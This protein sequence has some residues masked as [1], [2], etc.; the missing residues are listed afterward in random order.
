[1]STLS[2]SKVFPALTTPPRSRERSLAIRYQLNLVVFR[3]QPYVFRMT[4][5]RMRLSTPVSF[6]ERIVS[7]RSVGRRTNLSRCVESTDPSILRGFLSLSG[8]SIHAE[9]LLTYLLDQK[10]GD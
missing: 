1:M 9:S 10:S 7:R 8:P 3:F 2:R 6:E 5:R 4:H